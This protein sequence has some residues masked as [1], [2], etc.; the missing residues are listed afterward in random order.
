MVDVPEIQFYD[1]FK[2]PPR[3]STQTGKQT[4]SSIVECNTNGN[5]DR[6]KHARLHQ[7]VNAHR[8]YRPDI[9]GS[10]CTGGRRDSDPVHPGNRRSCVLDLRIDHKHDRRPDA[11]RVQVSNKTKPVGGFIAHFLLLALF[12]SVVV[13]PCASAITYISFSPLGLDAEDLH[14]YNATG[15]LVGT[16]NTTSA[17]VPFIDNQSYTILVVPSDE[18]LM[19]NHPDLW[20]EMFINKLKEN[21]TALFV[22][23]FCLALVI[24]AS[25]RR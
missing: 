4:T 5:N 22:V 12:L 18:N 3:Q 16:Y 2:Y 14:I 20:F 1:N 25:R 21:S 8:Q 15:E 11:Q 7:P 9:P 24:A 19:G 13:F 6:P 23:F 10:G 17:G